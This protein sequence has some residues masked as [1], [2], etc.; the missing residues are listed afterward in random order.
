MINFLNL[1]YFLVAAEELNFTKAAKKL[2]I[3]QQSLSSHIS[4][5]EKEFDVVLFNRTSP[6]T[7]T[8]AGHALKTRARELLDLRDETYREISD[9]KDFSTGQLSI[10]VSHTRGR[11][12]LPEILPVYQSRFPG[13][14]LRLVEGNSSELASDLIHGNIDLIID[15]LPFTAENVETV[16]IC[17]EEIL[18]AVPDEVLEKAYP[19]QLE[20]IKKKLSISADIR[21]LEN[22]PFVLLKKGNR[23]RTIA[24]EIFEDAQMTP[25]IV[26]ETENIE[27]VLALSCRGMGITF[28][29]K[30]F[31][32]S[33]Q[34]FIN[35]YRERSGLNLYTLDYARAHGTLGIGYHK[36]HYMSRATHEFILVA[37]EKIPYVPEPEKN[38]DTAEPEKYAD[39]T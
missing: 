16:P 6:L 12:I 14:E 22:C 10:G 3:S 29:P 32:S 35:V 31:I 7:L 8:Y 2:Y 36:G 27:T 25:N 23:V 20:E 4:N 9:I 19:G 33:E 1:E 24:D 11:V 15:L 28:Y 37:L 5:L 13:I 18:M 38:A 26:L 39:I 21:L 17:Q 30:M 34:S